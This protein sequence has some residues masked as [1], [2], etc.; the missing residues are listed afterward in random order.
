[1]NTTATKKIIHTL[2]GGGGHILNTTL[3]SII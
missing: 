2:Y 1:M 3:G